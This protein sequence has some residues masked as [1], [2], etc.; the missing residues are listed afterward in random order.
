MSAALAPNLDA[1]PHSADAFLAEVDRF[2]ARALTPDLREAGRNTIGTYSDIRACR[3]WH[4]RLFERGWIA[5][6]WPIEH[7]G[8]GWTPVQRML[9]E[10]ACA[11]NDAPIL[12][13]GGIRTLGPLLIAMGTPQQRA[14]YLPAILN[15]TDLWCQGFSE[16]GAGSDL[17]ALTT[18]AVR[19][20]DHYVVNGSKIWTTGAHIADRMFCLVRTAAGE[21][22]QDGITFLLIDMASSGISVRPI[23]SIAGEHEFNEV[24]FDRVR[25]PAENRVGDENEGWSAAKLLMRFARSNNTTSGLLRRALRRAARDLEAAGER[26]IASSRL[27]LAEAECE[28]VAFESLELKIMSSARSQGMSGAQASMLK[29][30]ATELH[31]KLTAIGLDI[32]PGWCEAGFATRKYFG[33]RAASIYSGTN[34]THRNLIWQQISGGGKRPV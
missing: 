12:F 29:T 19:V 13:A 21:R 9:F 16:T 14:R 6:A 23:V 5:P 8:T 11:E 17:A 33:T 34:E 18:R 32:G 30:V 4:R 24:I 3:I 27:K 26:D 7:G 15:G 28:L 1:N 10:R 2:L 20:G 22:P 31:Q 25:V